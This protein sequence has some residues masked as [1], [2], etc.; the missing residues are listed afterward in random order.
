M[1]KIGIG[2]FT[3]GLAAIAMSVWTVGADS[4]RYTYDVDCHDSE[5]QDNMDANME[6]MKRTRIVPGM[7]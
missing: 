6:R 5:A 2:L 4:A 7:I 1:K 3:V